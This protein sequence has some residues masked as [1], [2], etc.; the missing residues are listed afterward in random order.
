LL[1]QNFWAD[2]TILYESGFWQ[3]FAMTTLETLYAKNVISKLSFLLVTHTTCF[4]TQLDRY[5][6][7]KSGFSVG[8]I[9]DRLVIQV[10]GQAFWASRWVRLVGVYIQDLKIT[11]STF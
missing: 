11:C 4:D 8:Q 7:L 6:F 2:L 3:N 5:E 1:N 9:L 10:I